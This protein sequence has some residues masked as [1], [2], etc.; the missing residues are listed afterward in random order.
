LANKAT[1]NHS[2][3]KVIKIPSKIESHKKSAVGEKNNILV[4]QMRFF[5][6]KYVIEH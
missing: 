1:K 3:A 5:Y 2:K 4:F 6:Q